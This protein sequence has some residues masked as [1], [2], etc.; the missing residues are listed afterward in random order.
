MLE[1]SGMSSANYGATLA[2]W[3][4]RTEPQG[5]AFGATGIKYPSTAASA[6]AKLTGTYHWR[7][8]D[9]GRA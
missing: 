7:I 9:G 5:L 3:A 4:S 8:T 6:R 1:A 2:G